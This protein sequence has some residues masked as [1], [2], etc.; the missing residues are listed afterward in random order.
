MKRAHFVAAAGMLG[1]VRFLP[2]Q[3]QNGPAIR[4]G[5][6]AVEEF[7][8][9]YY[10]LQKGFFREAGLSVDL[11]II[12]GGGAITQAL[13]AG[14]LDVAVTNSGSM[15]SA[16]VRGLPLYLL[17]SGSVYSAI[18]PIAHVIVPKNSPIREAKDLA[19]KTVGVTTL[20][21]MIQAAAMT[22]IDKH[23]GDATAVKWFEIL[24]ASMGPAL[25]GGRIDAAVI[26]EP[27]YTQLAPNVTSIGLPYE[28]LNDGR[29][30][31]TTG[32]IGYK[33]WVDGNRQSARRFGQALLQTA[34]WANKN[35]D[36]VA[37]LLAQL[38]KVEPAVLSSMRRVSYATKNDPALAQP[39]IDAIARYGF[40]S[41]GF[42]ASELVAP[43]L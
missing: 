7:A 39:V 42:P 41:R 13:S 28:S 8:L 22:W 6:G 3:A 27:F 31:Q 37:A 14:A 20:R 2:A 43:G 40:I 38:T 5:T 17:T 11:T 9:P 19:G 16:H 26:V 21:D 25:A 1:A 18:Q 10:A 36:E 30:F 32:S 34:A 12:G 15:S 29:P 33:P 24:S 23:G 35:P 4:A